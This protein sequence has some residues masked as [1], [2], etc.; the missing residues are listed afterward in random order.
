[1]SKFPFGKYH[2]ALDHISLCWPIQ[3]VAWEPNVAQ[4]QPQSGPVYSHLRI[5]EN[6][7]TTTGLSQSRR[8]ILALK[9]H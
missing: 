6:H 7:F 5:V 8:L 9:E 1:M 4:T 2:E 3:I